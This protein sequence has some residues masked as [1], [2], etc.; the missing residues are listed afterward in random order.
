MKNETQGAGSRSWTRGVVVWGGALVALAGVGCGGSKGPS[1]RALGLAAAQAGA[2]A[3][4][5]SVVEAG[6][7]V[8]ARE[9]HQATALQDGVTVLVTGGR[10]AR[11]SASDTAELWLGGRSRPVV[12]TL[13]TA[14]ADHA[15][16]RLPTGEVWV[17]GGH[18][19][20]GRPLASTEL[21]DPAT[22]AFRAGPALGAPRDGAAAL[23]VED[24]LVLAGGAGR[25]D[26]EGW[27]L[28]TL[29]PLGALPLA[30]GERRGG[31]LAAWSERLL[32]LA[33]GVDGAGQALAPEWLDLA[34]GAARAVPAPAGFTGGEPAVLPE[35]EARALFLLGGALEGAP[36]AG[37]W[38][39]DPERG[40]ERAR[41]NLTVARAGAVTV[42]VAHGALRVGGQVGAP[43][44]VA[45]TGLVEVVVPGGATAAGDALV[46]AREDAVAT[47]LGDGAVLVT[48]GR[49]A[50]GRPVGLA[51][52]ILPPGVAGPDAAAHFAQARADADA[53]ARLLALVARL[54]AEVAGLEQVR[55]VLLAR[56]AALGQDV[57]RAE[58]ER[59]QARA[60]V[61]QLEAELQAA[62]GRVA[63]LQ[64][65]LSATQ[66]AL[67]SAQGEAQRLA[68]EL[69]QAQGAARQAARQAADQA[70][71][72]AAERARADQAAADAQRAREEA[73][74]Q[75]A[76]AVPPPPAPKPV[77]ILGFEPTGFVAGGQGADSVTTTVRTGSVVAPRR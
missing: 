23:V 60:R 7:L 43:G 18:D 42:S 12:A 8:E 38:R 31:R 20:S 24:L 67:A 21:F 19:A 47:P 16:V 1:T 9:G 40:V 50:D 15:A 75:A 36:V 29:S 66:G 32:L 49:G 30:L 65:D 72:L 45:P 70:A 13:A 57:A 34:A 73:A 4:V 61:G 27:D 22:G 14:R 54:L 25:A 68:G 52:L 59:D 74:R 5:G 44:P 39:V 37:L 46:V 48:G 63:Q 77:Q 26:A 76:A 62:Q 3:A 64:G 71:Q 28:R 10:T 51:E 6:S 35:G 41:A 2:T 17:V 58:A 53:R 69:A 33:G 11:A 56:V 55:D